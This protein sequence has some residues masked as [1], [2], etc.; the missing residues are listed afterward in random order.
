MARERSG[1]SLVPNGLSSN[2]RSISQPH[3][4]NIDRKQI[5]I[6]TFERFN[7]VVSKVST[8]FL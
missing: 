4:Y 8:T 2:M 7:V 3:F 5:C 6:A 1:V